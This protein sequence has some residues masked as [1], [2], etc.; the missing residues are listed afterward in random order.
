MRDR[1]SRYHT[2]TMGRVPLRSHVGIV[3]V[4]WCNTR[5]GIPTPTTTITTTTASLRLQSL[6]TATGMTPRATV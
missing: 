1:I 4:L 3:V 2:V 6:I 5:A